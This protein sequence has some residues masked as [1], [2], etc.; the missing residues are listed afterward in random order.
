MKA[1][2]TGANGQLGREIRRLLE[3][4]NSEIGPIP[5]A[6]HSAEVV[7]ADHSM[8]D[9]G[10]DESVRGVFDR[11]GPFDIVINCAAATNVDRCESDSFGA[12]R[13]NAYGPELLARSCNATG[14]KLLHVSTDYVFSGNDPS[15]RTE[16]DE[17]DPQ[18]IYG[19]SKRAGELLALHYCPRTFVVRTAWLYGYRG[20]NFVRTIL[21]IARQNGAIKVVADQFGNPTSANDLAHEI[22][23]LAPTDEFGIYH[24]T[25]EGTCSWYEFACAIV[26]EAHVACTKTPCTTEEFPRP[27]PRPHFS[28]LA[29]R[30]FEE[31]IGSEMRPWRQALANFLANLESQAE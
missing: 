4:G 3:T 22:L 18:S 21:R 20:G 8:L 31:T 14:A 13:V 12:Y 23:R 6:W 24:C 11:L 30:H 29:N 2:V 10:S 9:I 19:A 5:Q 15:P 16:A 25:N 17:A 28:S 27:A 26:D 7:Y 1:L